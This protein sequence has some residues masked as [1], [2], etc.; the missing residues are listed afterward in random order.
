M[1]TN[2]T[3]DNT[4]IDALKWTAQEKK[5]KYG[6]STLAKHFHEAHHNTS[7]LRWHIIEQVHGTDKYSISKKISTTQGILD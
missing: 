4:Q 2:Q 7:D 6:E 1:S 3:S 5:C